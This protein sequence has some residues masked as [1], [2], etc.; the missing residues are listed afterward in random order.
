[1]PVYAVLPQVGKKDGKGLTA[2][3]FVKMEEEQG[4]IDKV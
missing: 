3:G 1:M 2:G 4:Q